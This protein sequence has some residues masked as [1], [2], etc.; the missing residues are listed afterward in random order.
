MTNKRKWLTIE[1]KVQILED[2]QKMKFSHRKLS[3][4][5]VVYAIGKMQIGKLL[6]DQEEFLKIWQENGNHQAKKKLKTQVSKIDS[7]LFQWSCAAR[8][9]NLPISGLIIQEKA[10]KVANELQ[11]G[12]DFKAFNGWLVKFKVRHNITWKTFSRESANVCGATVSEWQDKLKKFCNGYKENNIFFCEETGLFYKALLNKTMCDRKDQCTGGKCSKAKNNMFALKE[13][14]DNSDTAST[15]AE[16]EDFVYWPSS[17]L[18][19]A[20]HSPVTGTSE[21]DESGSLLFKGDVDVPGF[22]LK[23]CKKMTIQSLS[24]LSKAISDECSYL[25]GNWFPSSL[26]YPSIPSSS[27]WTPEE[28]EDEEESLKLFT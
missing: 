19:W 4:R 1:E 17:I 7:I 3:E 21:K 26:K 27:S 15:L 14:S 25:F 23:V 22:K 13:A 24:Y 2:H 28:V 18:N 12:N 5:R 8:N 11:L 16:V 9:K 10:L 20:W 6:K